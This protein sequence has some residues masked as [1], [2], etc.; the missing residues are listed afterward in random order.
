MLWRPNIRRPMSTDGFT[1]IELL[2]V[3]VIIAVLIA[4]A[5]PSYIGFKKRAADSAAK[6]NLRAALPAAEAFYADS[7][8]Y[9]GMTEPALRLIDAG[10]ASSLTVVTA[11]ATGYCLAA[12]VSG[13]T[14][15][16][17]GPGTPLP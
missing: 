12:T 16:V 1:L 14:W 9:V 4:I 15:S 11:T 6:A 5:V 7:K 10:L 3:M 2:V 17:N 8:T 13:E